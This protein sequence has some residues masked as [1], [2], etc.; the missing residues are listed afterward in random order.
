MRLPSCISAFGLVLLSSAASVA[1]QYSFEYY[2]VDRGLTNLAVRSLYQDKQGYLWM[3]TENS[4]FRYDGERFQELGPADGLPLSNAAMFGEAPD[5]T[6]LVGGKFGLYRMAATGRHFESLPMP[7]ATR[8]MWGSSIQS[9]GHGATYIATE[10]GV[11]LMTRNP[12]GSLQMR[13]L[14]APAHAGTPAANGLLIE[15]SSIW[16]G[17]GDEICFSGSG[18]SSVF[19]PGS[20]ILPGQWRAMIRAGNGDLWAQTTTGK[21]A[22]MR[23]GSNRFGRAN[24][25]RLPDL[26]ARGLIAIDREG[27]VLIPVADGMLVEEHGRWQRVT[28]AAGLYGPVYSVLQDR[29]GSV[30]VGLAGH[31]LAKW[32]GYGEWAHFNSDSGLR[33]DLA[34]EVA[35]VANGQFW[36]GTDEGLFLG[37]QT[38]DGWNWTRHAA[39][40]NVAIH[41]VRS[42]RHGKLWLGTENRGAARFDP[43]TGQV[44]WFDKTQG[45][46]AE[47]P[48]TLFLDRKNRIWAASMT[49]LFV[50]DLD[51]LRFRPVEGLPAGLFCLAIVESPNGDIWAGTQQG[52]Y[53]LANGHWSQFTTVQGL[54]N[55]EILSLAAD[56]TGTIW[57]GYQFGS[58]IDRLRVSADG[59]TVTAGKFVPSPAKGT[60]YFLGFDARGRLWAG[61]DRGVDVLNG[62]V[63][64]G[65]F[66]PGAVWDH[67]DHHDG[68]VWDD[69]DLN[70]FHANPDGTVWLGTSGGLALFTPRDTEVQAPPVTILTQ[71]TLG[72]SVVDATRTPSVDHNANSLTARFSALTF[73]REDAVTFRYRLSPLFRDWRET[74]ERELEFPGLPPA[75]YRLEVQARNGWGKLSESPAVFNFEVKPPYWQ[76]WWFISLSALL[77][78]AMA[79]ALLRLRLQSMRRRECELLRMVDERTTEMKNVNCCLERTTSQLQEANRHLMQLSTLDGLTGISNRRS[80]DATLET[81]WLHARRAGTPFSVVMADIDFFKRLNDSAGH[82][83]GD[84]CLKLVA[85]ALASAGKRGMDCI[86]RY[87]GEEFAMLLPGTDEAHAAALA[88]AARACVHRLEFPHPG[89]PFGRRVTISLG[90]ATLSG[91]NYSSPCELVKAAD[92]ALYTAK[93]QGRNRVVVFDAARVQ[94]DIW[95][96]DRNRVAETA[97]V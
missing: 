35:P 17:C 93:A 19:G 52:L 87:G 2:G 76:S 16:W 22:V 82:Q 18:T 41:S 79:A 3:S 55:T 34:Y 13:L 78:L 47:S 40:G 26:E 67:Y 63:R 58:R 75:S 32:L 70:G 36:A 90:V 73:A 68:L 85:Q 12:E 62:D 38:Q 5:G 43:Q 21:I 6:L 29:E 94:Q 8:V 69:C 4:V 71:L 84:E 89:S 48:Y 57:V 45:L 14:S 50:A 15:G 7:G 20:G 72:K 74:H 42:D 37:K 86:A 77:A 97:P 9:D 51:E 66:T 59:V 95:N 91:G 44:E 61:T 88:E 33:S 27:N 1:Q 24:L 11:V 64:H 65:A 25:P 53:R 23:H 31:G 28:R 54:T 56:D 60:T 81:E 92:T 80:F 96:L 30:W 10:A 39:L 49:G 83:T 46:A